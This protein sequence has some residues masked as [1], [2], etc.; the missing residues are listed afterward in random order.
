MSGLP[1]RAVARLRSSMLKNALRTAGEHSLLK[2][3]VI[4]GMVALILGGTYYVPYRAFVFLQSMGHLGNVLIDRLLYIFFM[5]LFFMLVFS[6]AVICYT[7]HYKARETAFLLTLPLGYRR[8]FFIKF[9]DCLISSSWMF[10]CFLLPVLSAYAVVRQ[11]PWFFYPAVILFFVPFAVIAAAVGCM[12]VMALLRWLPRRLFRY[13]IYLFGAVFLFEMALLFL[14][15]RS[16]Q[17]QPDEF[18]FL[19]TNIIPQFGFA[20]WVF[21]PNYWLSEGFFRMLSRYYADSMFWWALLLSNALFLTQALIAL[22][23]KW[24]YESWLR[25]DNFTESR[26][27]IAGR[28]FSDRLLRRM[29]FLSAPVRALTVKDL[30][31]FVRDP[32]QWSQFTIFFGLLGIYFA[33]LRSLGYQ[34]LVPFWKN[35]ICFLNLACT[36]LTMGSLAV[37]FIFPQLSLEGKRFW[38]LGLSPLRK[39][40]LLLQKFGVNSA[41]ALL[42]CVP[43]IV[44]SNTMLQVSP[45]L[46]SLSLTAAMIMT[47]TLIALCISLG[48]LFPS[49]KEDNP[50]K[51]VSGF[52]GTLALVI[53]LVYIA[54]C[55]GG[56]GIPFHLLVTGAIGVSRFHHMLAAACLVL[57]VGSLGIIY[58]MMWLAIRRL[59]RMEF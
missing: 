49:L 46:M 58:G 44:V 10:L 8:I 21:A 13:V 17:N 53:C 42:I 4:F 22:A 12:M 9:V 51:I 2:G 39:S 19:L 5:G 16:A 32:A 24:Y 35:I 33:N 41:T 31:V 28:G 3:T 55:V 34:E 6:N 14:H 47:V 48:T 38:I 52:G 27:Y 50:A 15:G 18:L 26:T 25:A 57:G 29:R 59:N 11:S 54:V 1:L 30:K 23:G 37:R 36:N 56:L 7:T 40:R 43:L 20:Q 45:L